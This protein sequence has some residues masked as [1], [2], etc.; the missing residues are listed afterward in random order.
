VTGPGGVVLCGL[1]VDPGVT[2]GE[3]L[4]AYSGEAA[5]EFEHSLRGGFF[6]GTWT[7]CEAK[8][9]F[10]AGGQY[11]CGI[12]WS[13]NGTS[14]GEQYQSTRLVSRFVQSFSLVENT[15][16]PI[17][18]DV[19]RPTTYYR[20]TVPYDEGTLEVLWSEDEGAFPNQMEDWTSL[21][22]DGDGEEE[23]ENID[24]DYKTEFEPGS[25]GQ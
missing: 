13:V 25:A 7:G 11:V 2:P 6:D 3:E 16:S 24:F 1:T 22:W 20:I 18:P 5:I 17:H 15:C 14:Y 10:D 12:K 19:F 4:A 9:F 21:P 8:H 23:P